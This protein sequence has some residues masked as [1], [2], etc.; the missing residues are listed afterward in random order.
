MRSSI[1]GELANAILDSLSIG[2]LACDEN[3][4]I[5]YANKAFL[6]ARKLSEDKLIGRN[7]IGCHMLDNKT[8][9]SHILEDVRKGIKVD[10]EKI[11]SINGKD[12][13]HVIHPIID[14]NGKYRGLTLISCDISRET[15]IRDHLRAIAE[16]DVLTGLYNRLYFNRIMEDMGKDFQYG[17][18]V[19]LVMVDI[20]GLKIINDMLGHLEGDFI[21]RKCSQILRKSVRKEDLL[22]RIGGDEFVILMKNT[23]LKEGKVVMERIR[24]QCEEWN[25]TRG[26][27]YGLYLSMGVSSAITAAEFKTLLH[28]ADQAMYWD[29]KE[30]YAERE[31]IIHYGIMRQGD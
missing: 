26:K 14:I 20:N 13:D 9:I 25:N 8:R 19:L 12:F 16:T 15:R 27:P 10:V 7:I 4:D 17:T 21:I 1:A 30:F 6:K 28:R 5:F 22:F 2:I 31:G 11:L 29:K 24:A 23:D 18:S 3:G